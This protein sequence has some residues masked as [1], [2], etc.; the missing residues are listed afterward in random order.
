MNRLFP[1][2]I[3]SFLKIAIANGWF[4][5]KGLRNLPPW[6][7]KTIFFEPLRWAELARNKKIK[8]H[9]LSQP[10]LF[11]LGFYRSGTTYLQQLFMQDDRLGHL[12]SFQ[13]VFPEIILSCERWMTP[14]L[15]RLVRLLKIKNHVHRIPLTWN[16][17]GEEDVAMTTFCNPRGAQ[18]GYFFPKKMNDYFKKYVLFE[19]TTES[20]TEKW[21]RDYRL[22]VKK[23]SMANKGRQLVLKSP[24]NT[25]RIKLLLSMFPGARFIHI[26]RN[27]YDVFASN[28]R[29]WKVVQFGYTIGSTK[30]FDAEPVILDTYAATMTRYLE[31]RAVIP[32]GQ[33]VELRYDDLVER[34][35]EHMKAI[36]QALDLGDFGY[37]EERITRYTEEQKKYEKLQHRLP[38]EETRLVTE[39]WEPFIRQWNYPVQTSKP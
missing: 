35:V 22:L 38:E 20:E 15:E 26:H 32:Q 7:L 37:F 28:K 6:L 23:V 13:M 14:W 16:T 3:Y 25:A 10:P 12:S 1:L 31:E 9:V 11:I 39:R 2:P 5:W 34:P 8:Q 30:G 19:G 21:K 29:L 18:W 17:P 4:S 27:P 36:Y 33:L 24:P